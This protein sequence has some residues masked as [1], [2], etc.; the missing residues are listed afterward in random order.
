MRTLGRVRE[1]VRVISAPATAPMRVGKLNLRTNKPWSSKL[2]RSLHYWKQH[3]PKQLLGEKNG[4]N[5]ARAKTNKRTKKTDENKYLAGI[6]HRPRI[7]SG[8]RPRLKCLVGA[9]EPTNNFKRPTLVLGR[10]GR[11][12]PEQRL[13]VD[14]EGWSVPAQTNQSVYQSRHAQEILQS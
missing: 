8:R 3:G 9:A 4:R 6:V 5:E 2:A 12:G 11:A 10:L 7:W 1:R 14:V 13:A